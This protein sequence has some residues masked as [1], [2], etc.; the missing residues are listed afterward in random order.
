MEDKEARGYMDL[1]VSGDEE[2]EVED[3][4]LELEEGDEV[5][6]LNEG[7]AV[8]A[9]EEGEDQATKRPIGDEMRYF[10][11]KNKNK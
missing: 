11:N 2:S 7:Y 6:G 5:G 1:E 10:K 4:E 9:P 3:D 8:G